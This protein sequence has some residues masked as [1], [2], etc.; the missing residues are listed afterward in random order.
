MRDELRRLGVDDGAIDE[1]ADHAAA[2]VEER[3]AAGDDEATAQAV[4]RARM[5]EP[6]VLA[7]EY[8][9]A[10]PG[11]GAAPS[12]A[13]AWIGGGALAV[14]F[15]L[16]PLAAAALRLDRGLDTQLASDLGAL[17]RGPALIA[18]A[19]VIA[20]AWRAA[21]AAAYLLGCALCEL[22]RWVINDLFGGVSSGHGWSIAAGLLLLVA[23]V[24]LAR[25]RFTRWRGAAVALG[26]MVTATADLAV[27]DRMGLAPLHAAF[28]IAAL[29]ALVALGMRA[30][31]APLLGGLTAVLGVVLVAT[32]TGYVGQHLDGPWQVP[33]WYPHAAWAWHSHAVAAIANLAIT[34]VAAPIALVALPWR[35]GRTLAGVVAAVR[36]RFVPVR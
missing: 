11:F 28:P 5:G 31:V 35:G 21:P 18:T 4:A 10:R 19:M 2:I 3:R 8:A 15:V 32:G 1:L 33:A 30:R 23:C 36:R 20:L 6:A 34:L 29:V 14:Y 26:W 25:G 24:A 9:R 17:V 27:L 12:H 13:A 7:R 16:G 22:S